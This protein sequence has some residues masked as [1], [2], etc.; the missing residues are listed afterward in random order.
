MVI[1]CWPIAEPCRHGVPVAAV[2]DCTTLIG[3]H[4]QLTCV[5]LYTSRR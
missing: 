1:E 5:A 4:A 2:T 3:K